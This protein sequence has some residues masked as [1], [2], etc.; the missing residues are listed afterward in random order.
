MALEKALQM[1][2]TEPRRLCTTSRKLTKFQKQINP[3]SQIPKNA[4]RCDR[5]LQ[6]SSTLALAEGLTA[7]GGA[8]RH[9]LGRLLPS[10]LRH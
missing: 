8:I 7:N 3:M 9:Q 6:L 10:R 5:S 1:L 4:S 2:R